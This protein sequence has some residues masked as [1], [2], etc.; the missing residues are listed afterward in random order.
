MQN[1]E[2]LI[3]TLNRINTEDSQSMQIESILIAKH[4]VSRGRQFH[5]I[6][7]LM[8]SRFSLSNSAYNASSSSTV[9]IFH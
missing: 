2:G 6:I 9:R 5:L 7:R 4:S 1:S 8:L 3:M